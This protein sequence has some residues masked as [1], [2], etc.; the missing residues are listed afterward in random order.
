MTEGP[1]NRLVLVVFTLGG[2]GG[3]V[4]MHPPDGKRSN[5]C[6][7]LE[8]A[9]ETQLHRIASFLF[10]GFHNK[11][12]LKLFLLNGRRYRLLKV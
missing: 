10:V 9:E 3:V 11:S 5:N 2:V 4:M 7:K 12:M 6:R 8:L 1:Q